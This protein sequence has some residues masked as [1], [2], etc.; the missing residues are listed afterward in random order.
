MK[1][2]FIIH[3][4][5]PEP[6]F[7]VGLPFARELARRGHSVQVLTGFPNYPGGKLYDGYKLKWMQK[8]KM[9]GVS[10]IRL[11]LYPSHD[12]SS[13]RRIL[14]Y[15]SLALSQTCIGS[16]AVDSADVAFVSQGPATVGLP[17]VV[18]KLLR[19]IP[20]VYNIQDLWPDSLTTTGMFD[21]SFG[22]KL[23]NSWC[24]FVYKRA[25][26]IAVITPGMRAKL[27]ERGVS[28]DKVEVVYNWCDNALICRDSPD[29]QLAQKLGMKGKFN[30]VFAGNMG[31]VQ[32][33]E[34]VLDSARLLMGR[35]PE[36]QFVFFGEGV[37]VES[38]KK[39]A[40]L[41]GLINVLFRARKPIS[42]IG[43]ILRLADV[44]LVHLK[45][46]PLFEITIP[47]KTQAYLAL[48]RPIL[49]GVKG[50]TA[51]LVRK[52]E[53]GICVEPENPLSIAE[54]IETL[55]SM[56]PSEREKI[57]SNGMRFYDE[58]LSFD[59]AVS[60]YETIF[61]TGKKRC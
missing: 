22:L 58:N 15:T 6:N 2:L 32:A 21:S 60:H 4:F 35:C 47:S 33:L 17:A 16:F 36:L 44:L 49:V 7:F 8:E 14:C 18:I 25:A 57:G 52:A 50:D 29:Q 12:R 45:N 61:E 37:E 20:F 38:L 48:G 40:M 19:R 59:A 26:K 34:A 31:R 43:P 53:A 27:L 41:L 30:V 39:K 10:V 56:K 46:D 13:F 24:N 9:D 28:Q 3:Y 23:V 11:P 5:Q 51:E 42:E 55:Y 1:I 54:G